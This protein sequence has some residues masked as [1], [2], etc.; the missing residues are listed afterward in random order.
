MEHPSQP[1]L[2]SLEQDHA[3]TVFGPQSVSVDWQATVTTWT[4]R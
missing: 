1:R 3:P 2:T 4:G